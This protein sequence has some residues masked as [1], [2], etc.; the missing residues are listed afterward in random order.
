VIPELETRRLLLRPL[1]LEDAAQ[2]QEIF[3][4]WEI[5]RYLAN[6]VPWPFPPDAAL[7]YFR[8]SALPAIARGD[9]WVWTLR[10]KTNPNRLI[11]V[12]NLMKGEEN[13]RGFWIG[14]PWQRQGLMSEAVHAVTDYWFETLKYPCLR[15]PKAV[16]NVP[17]R[18]ISEKTGMR[19]V[20]VIEREYVSGRFPTEV[21]EITAEEWKARRATA[22][23]P[24]TALPNNPELPPQKRPKQNAQTA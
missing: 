12:I 2:V 17:S 7:K 6:Q 8:D 4:H 16:P 14:T 21:W 24:Q 23:A 1:Q 11:G 20:E 13:N 9:S 5:V 10:L 19:V 22:E 3:P 18:R 15:V